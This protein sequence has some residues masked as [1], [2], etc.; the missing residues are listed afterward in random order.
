MSQESETL[1]PRSTLP[2]NKIDQR[3]VANQ[4]CLTDSSFHD[5][6]LAGATFDDVNLSGAQIRNANLSGWK[7]RDV[8]FSGLE[9]RESDLRGVSIVHCLTDGMTIHGI[10]VD[11]LLA[12]HQKAQAR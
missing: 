9:L 10:P 12:A 3:I 7:V 8:T 11:E 4:C 1:K 5:V 2:F 6:N